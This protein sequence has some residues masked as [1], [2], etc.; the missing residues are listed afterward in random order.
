MLLFKRVLLCPLHF[1]KCQHANRPKCGQFYIGSAWSVM[2]CLVSLYAPVLDRM[3]YPMVIEHRES[4]RWLWDLLHVEPMQ[5]SVHMTVLISFHEGRCTTVQYSSNIEH[6]QE[7][8]FA[9]IW[10]LVTVSASSRC[11]EHKMTRSSKLFPVTL[12]PSM[13]LLSSRLDRTSRQAAQRCLEQRVHGAA[14]R[15]Y[16]SE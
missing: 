8:N 13:R 11:A 5:R 7:P 6:P 14:F 16:S 9:A 4:C 2:N 1:G 3:I 10:L 12:C 15:V